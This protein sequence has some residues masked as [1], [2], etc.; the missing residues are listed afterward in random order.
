MKSGLFTRGFNNN[1]RCIETLFWKCR[2]EYNTVF[3]NNIRCIETEKA[4]KSYNSMF[5]FNNNIRCI[6]TAGVE[7]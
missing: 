7:T 5:A 4:V 1:I 3:N 2:T 6:E